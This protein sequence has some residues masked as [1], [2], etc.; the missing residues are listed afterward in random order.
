MDD[1]DSFLYTFYSPLTGLLWDKNYKND[2][3]ELLPENRKGTVGIWNP[4]CGK[5]LESYSIACSV[6]M[7]YPDIHCKVWANDNSLIDISTAPSLLL[8]EHDIP[9]YFKQKKY[10]VKTEKGYKF[11]KEI[12][13]AIFFEYHDILSDNSIPQVDIIIA[14]DILSFFSLKNQIDLLSEFERLLKGDGVLFI[15]M[16]ERIQ[17]KEWKRIGNTAISAYIKNIT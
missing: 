7:K 16:N 9:E 1:A 10:V 8:L 17:N 14:R 4:G 15:G 2:V 5:G 13:D 3:S 12:I 6:K 11:S